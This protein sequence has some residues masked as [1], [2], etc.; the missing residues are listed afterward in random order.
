MYSLS[1]FLFI[2]VVVVVV[3]S[4]TTGLGFDLPGRHVLACQLISHRG[5][6]SVGVTFAVPVTSAELV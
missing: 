2:V 5:R 3:F 4:R 6:L 1:L